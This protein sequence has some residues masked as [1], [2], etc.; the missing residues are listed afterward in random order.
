MRSLLVPWSSS[1]GA[2]RAPA[3]AA[4]AL[5]LDLHRVIQDSGGLYDVLTSEEVLES[6]VA[7]EREE[8]REHEEFVAPSAALSFLELSKVTPLGPELPTSNAVTRA[9]RA[10]ARAHPR[11]ADPAA[12]LPRGRGRPDRRR[13]P[14]LPRGAP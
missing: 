3:S 4:R 10:A 7:S 5:L 8:R 14:E 11:R 12:D 1:R 6:D 13:A 2:P 9:F